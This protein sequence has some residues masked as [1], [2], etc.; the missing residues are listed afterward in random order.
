MLELRICLLQTRSYSLAFFDRRA[1]TCRDRLGNQFTPIDP[2]ARCEIKGVPGRTQHHSEPQ[3][4]VATCLLSAASTY[5][6]PPSHTRTL[7]FGRPVAPSDRKGGSSRVRG[8]ST[9]EPQW[10][11]PTTRCVSSWKLAFIS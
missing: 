3:P 11:Y 8:G 9:G 5:I 10:R 7:A 1:C 2:A 6:S 4:A